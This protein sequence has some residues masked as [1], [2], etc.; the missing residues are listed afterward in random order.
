[1]AWK[2]YFPKAELPNEIH[3]SRL[4]PGDFATVKKKAEFE[5]YITHTSLIYS[6]LEE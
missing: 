5:D 3:L 6:K 2:D 1:M 4:C